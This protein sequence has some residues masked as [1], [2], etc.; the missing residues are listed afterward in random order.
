MIGTGTNVL[1]SMLSRSLEQEAGHNRNILTNIV[2]TKLPISI[3][4]R[5]SLDKH[6]IFLIWIIGENVKKKPWVVSPGI[7]QFP[8]NHEVHWRCS[9][10]NK[11]QNVALLK[12]WKVL[13]MNLVDG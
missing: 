6:P 11:C 4:K 3:G 10:H 9:F 1:C 13:F 7:A 5:L 12:K 2:S 8:T